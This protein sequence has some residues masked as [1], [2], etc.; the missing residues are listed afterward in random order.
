MFFGL[1]GK[2]PKPFFP[3]I[4]PSRMFTLSLIIVFLIITFDPI[5]QLDP[6]TT[7]FL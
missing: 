4:E 6:I 7:F 3:I 5:E 2:K 1:F